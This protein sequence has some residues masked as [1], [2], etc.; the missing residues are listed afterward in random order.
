MTSAAAGT[1]IPD[2]KRKCSSLNKFKWNRNGEN[3][4]C[5]NRPEHET[6]SKWIANRAF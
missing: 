3:M 6:R 2:G 4:G 1:Q 5:A